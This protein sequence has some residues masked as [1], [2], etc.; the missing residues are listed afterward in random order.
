MNALMN[1]SPSTFRLI[2]WPSVITLAVSLARL[3]GEKQGWITEQSGGAMHPLGIFWLV[4]AFGA[5]FGWQHARAGALP[6]VRR[7]WLWA[8]VAGLAIFGTIGWRM[9]PMMNAE[10]SEETF[11]LLRTAVLTVVVVASAGAVA[12]FVVWPQFARTLLL[13]GLIARATVVAIT[14]FVKVQ[15]WHLH[16]VKFG[17]PGIERESMQDTV[18]SAS[19]AQ[20]GMWLPITIVVGT[21]IGSLFA[22]GGQSA[23]SQ[24]S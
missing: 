7:A 15:D 6:R 5:W 24:A 23:S 20:F 21:L 10:R 12:M 11:A 4:L 13:Y 17:P 14:W 3:V 2:L 18:V 16:Y 9:Q 1:D 8:L 19:I 22:R